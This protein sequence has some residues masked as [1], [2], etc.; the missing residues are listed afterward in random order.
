M[1]SKFTYLTWRLVPEKI[2]F[3]FL[4]AHYGINPFNH[5][6][7]MPIESNNENLF[8]EYKKTLN[9]FNYSKDFIK[10]LEDGKERLISQ[11]CLPLHPLKKWDNE[12]AKR[13]NID[14]E[15]SSELASYNYSQPEYGYMK[16]CIN[17]DFIIVWDSTHRDESI[18]F[19][20]KTWIPIFCGK[21]ILFMYKSNALKLFKRKGYKSWPML[22]D[23]SYDSMINQEERMDMIAKQ[24]VEL[25][26]KDK[27]YFQQAGVNCELNKL[28]SWRRGVKCEVF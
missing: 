21:P 17:S 16:A 4:L 5:F 15:N 13:L 10:K 9:R 20:E 11:G 14:I 1:M 6:I 8:D 19:T 28:H 22:F 25:Q 12:N 23:E 7:G 18:M 24:V 2:H 3:L 26:S 27:N